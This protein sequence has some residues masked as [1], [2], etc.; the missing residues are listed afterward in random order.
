MIK[1]TLHKYLLENAEYYPIVTLTGPRQSGKTTL[2]R[3]AFP[4][5]AYV[6]LEETESRF[7]ARDNPREFLTRYSGPVIIDEAQRV[8]ELFSYIQ[9]AVDENDSSGRFILTGSQNFLLIEK[10]SQSLA[11]RCAILHLLPFS[12]SE[13]EKRE[14]AIPDRIEN[15]F[16]SNTKSNSDLWE[17]IYNGF[18]PRIHDR[19]IPPEIWLSDYVQTYLQ[20]DV[21]QLVNIGDLERFERFLSL[22]AGRTGQILNFS[23]LADSCGISV[24]TA[25]RWISVLKTSFIVFLLKPHHKNFNKRI[26][27]SPKLYFY[28]TGLAC[29]LLRIRNADQAQLHPLRGAL[30]ENYIIAE[31]AKSYYH[32]RMEPP[33][34]FWRDQTGHEIDL[35]IQN[36]NQ[37]FPVEI[38]SSQTVSK[39]MFDTLKWWSDQAGQKL[40]DATLIYGGDESYTR[41]DISIRPWHSV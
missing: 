26:I 35:L 11:G 12:H 21:R 25:K 41:D 32:H 16:T 6:S 36:H 24:D 5:H 17:T 29:H 20:R 3:K 31:V 7:F 40:S 18:Y 27:K 8:P 2:V 15:L 39:S 4:E 19:S 1:R 13:L 14:Q 30:F 34:A 22:V 23:V 9:T 10:V 37:L 28:D 33:T 38:K